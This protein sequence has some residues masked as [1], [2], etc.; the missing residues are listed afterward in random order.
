MTHRAR[1]GSSGLREGQGARRIWPDS[2]GR[3]WVSEW[4]AGKLAVYN[5]RARRWREWRLPGD[6]P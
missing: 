3:L 6:N 2:P 5:P 4:N 1:Y